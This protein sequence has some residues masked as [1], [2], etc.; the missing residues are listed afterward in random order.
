MRVQKDAARHVRTFHRFLIEHYAGNFPL[1][2]APEQVRLL[3]IGDD[4]KLLDY[5]KAIHNELPSQMVRAGADFTPDPI[6]ARLPTSSRPKSIPQCGSGNI[7]AGL[8]CKGNIGAKP[9]G[10]VVA[11]ILTAIRKRRTQTR[12]VAA[13]WSNPCG[14]QSNRYCKKSDPLIFQSRFAKK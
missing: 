14:R 6:K 13:V 1:W 12:L 9:K 7:S 5:A 11:E 10:E 8:H 2:L 4:P 3:T